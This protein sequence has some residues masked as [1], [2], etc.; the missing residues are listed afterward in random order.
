M[1]THIHLTRLPACRFGNKIIIM[2]RQQKRS[3]LKYSAHLFLKELKV[4]GNY[5]NNTK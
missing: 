2:V 3:L 4:H 1:P 5:K